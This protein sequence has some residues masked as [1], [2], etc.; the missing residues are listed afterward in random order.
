MY[1]RLIMIRNIATS[2][3]AMVG[4]PL[5]LGAIEVGLL[6]SM[7]LYGIMAAQAYTYYTFNSAGDNRTIRVIVGVFDLRQ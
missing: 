6:L 1:I 2:L 4:L 3:S 7:I 5:T